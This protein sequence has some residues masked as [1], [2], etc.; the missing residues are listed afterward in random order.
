MKSTSCDFAR[1][2]LRVEVESFRNFT[3]RQE[4]RWI[5]FKIS[6]EFPVAFLPRETEEVEHSGSVELGSPERRIGEI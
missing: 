6:V 2:H 4:N 5:Y 3:Q 1:N